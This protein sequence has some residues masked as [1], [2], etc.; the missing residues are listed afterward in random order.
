MS[1][2]AYL[3]IGCSEIRRHDIDDASELS[4]LT[5]YL[6]EVGIT[7]YLMGNRDKIYY[8]DIMNTK[9][10]MMA[11][12][13]DI[14]YRPMRDSTST[15]R[16]Q[17]YWKRL[18]MFS[19]RWR[20]YLSRVILIITRRHGSPTTSASMKR[21]VKRYLQTSASLILI[22]IIVGIRL[23]EDTTQHFGNSAFHG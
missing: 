15:Q 7:M 8:D 11:S 17:Q 4:R 20:I 22:E 6:S 9:A 18:P 5:D 19:Q 14:T 2:C 10:V 13:D 16:R 12:V 21:N 23:D 1:V 3:C